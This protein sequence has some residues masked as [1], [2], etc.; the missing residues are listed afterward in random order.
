MTRETLIATNRQVTASKDYKNFNV[1]KYDRNFNLIGY[2][3]NRNQAVIHHFIRKN[4]SRQSVVL[5]YLQWN[6]ALRRLMENGYTWDNNYYVYVPVE[7]NRTFL[8]TLPTNHYGLGTKQKIVAIN[9]NGTEKEYSSFIEITKELNM[10]Y[11]SV[12]YWV[13]SGRFLPQKNC[14]IY[15]AGKRKYFNTVK[16]VIKYYHISKNTTKTQ[17]QMKKKIRGQFAMFK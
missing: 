3:V 10:P 15:R 4:L 1:A 16:D 14:A 2:Y 5:K 12:T 13:D 17:I 7:A 9:K 8:H 11:P 6:R